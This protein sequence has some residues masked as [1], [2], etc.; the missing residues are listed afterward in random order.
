MTEGGS[1]AEVFN[2]SMTPMKDVA[3][4]SSECFVN[5]GTSDLTLKYGL[6]CILYLMNI[7]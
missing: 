4:T 2:I 3:Q 7:D 5:C 6:N 1:R